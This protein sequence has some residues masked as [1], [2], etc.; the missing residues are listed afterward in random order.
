[1]ISFYLPLIFIRIIAH[2]PDC[3]TVI[4]IFLVFHSQ[5][6]SRFPAVQQLFGVP[7]LFPGIPLL[8][9]VHCTLSKG[10]SSSGHITGSPP[11]Q[12]PLKRSAKNIRIPKKILQGN[13]LFPHP[14]LLIIIIL[15]CV[16]NQ[17]L[18]SSANHSCLIFMRDSSK[19]SFETKKHHL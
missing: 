18:F 8:F 10:K 11:K 6:R 14:S 2:T 13:I 1:M 19:N 15:S 9:W 17:S 7:D 3:H 16:E 12:Q 5:H 4:R